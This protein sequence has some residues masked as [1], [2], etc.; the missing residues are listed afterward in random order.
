MRYVK[1]TLILVVIAVVVGFFHYSLPQHDVVRIT[2]TDVTRMDV[3]TTPDGQVK[4][5]D[6]R[7]IFA[8]YPD[9]RDMEYRNEDTGWGFP[10][11]F[12]FDSARLQNQA[13]DLKST[14]DAPKWV[15]IRHYG[16]RLPM[17][18]WF[19][20]ATSLRVASGPTDAGFPWF[21]VVFLAV[22]ALI[23]LSLVR[24]VIILRRRHVDPVVARID[25]ELDESAGWL[26]RQLRKLRG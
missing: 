8:K 24:I 4:T 7:F 15:V 5:R 22:L 21:N 25:Q 17:M 19:P 2:G 13:N 11:F 18:D 10:W 9:G 14:M 20:N 16:W 12:K 23:L 26:R 3:G 6:V 1:W